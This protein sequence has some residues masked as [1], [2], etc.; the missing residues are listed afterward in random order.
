MAWFYYTKSTGLFLCFFAE[1]DIEK[2]ILFMYFVNVQ[3]YTANTNHVVPVFIIHRYALFL[4]LVCES[5]YNNI[6]NC[7]FFV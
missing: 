6:G 4:P 2:F 7:N 3:F 5:F 1:N